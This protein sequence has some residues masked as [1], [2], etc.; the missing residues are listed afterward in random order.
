[1]MC[2][3]YFV[4]AEEQHMHTLLEALDTETTIRT[5]EIFPTNT[6]PVIAKYGEL[7]AMEWGF[8]RFDGKGC[9]INARSETAA[10]K[11]MFRIPMQLGRCLIPASWYF[12]WEKAGTSKIKHAIQMPE[13]VTYLAGLSRTE[14][15]GRTTCVIL[16]RQASDQIRYIHD[17]MP[18]ILQPKFHDEWL[19]GRMPNKVLEQAAT[20][21]LVRA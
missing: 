3:R 5:G 14:Q 13:P 15:D 18:V 4:D 11:A 8:P 1:M 20:G 7:T 6:V 21:V 2:G 9:I 12:E 19:H 10:E 17:R 16:T